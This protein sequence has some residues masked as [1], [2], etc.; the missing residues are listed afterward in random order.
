MH[1]LRT[2][3][4][5][6]ALL[7]ISPALALVGGAPPAPERLSRSVVMVVGSYGTL[8]TA[9]AV[10]RDLFD[11]GAPALRDGGTS[12]AVVG[13]VSWSTG[14]NMGGGCGG[15]TGINCARALSCLDH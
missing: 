12:L 9:T 1:R 2:L 6:L 3:V 5:T 14:P 4:A 11:S 13:L 7:A 10:A 15:V 8:Y